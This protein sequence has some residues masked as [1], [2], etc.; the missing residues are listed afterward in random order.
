VAAFEQH[1]ADSKKWLGEGHEQVHL[2]LDEYFK[3]LGPLHRKVRHHHEG[4][5]QIR[6][7]YGDLAAT[8]ATIHILRDCRH[9]PKASHYSI[10]FVDSLGLR[11][12]WPTSAYVK[13]SEEDFTA[14][15]QMNLKG[16]TGL[17]LWSFIN[18]ENINGFLAG[19]TTLSPEETARHVKRWSEA[20]ASRL[21]LAPFEAQKTELTPLPEPSMSYIRQ[22]FEKQIFQEI[23]GQLSGFQIGTVPVNQ[24]I[25]PLVYVD[26]EYL[27]ELRAELP[28][29]DPPDLVRFAFPEIVSSTIKIVS[30][31]P[32]LRS[33]TIVSPQKTLTIGPLQL[34]TGPAGVEAKFL[35]SNTLSM[36]MVTRVGDRLYLKNG[37]H[38]AFL[39]AQ[40]GI[41]EIPCIFTQESQL[42]LTLSVAYPAFHPIVL[43]QPRPPLLVDLLDS[44]LSVE[45]PI[46]RTRKFIKIS[47]EESII[48]V[49]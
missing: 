2:L 37:I 7:L 3:T 28:G 46:H 6:F 27:E 48:P 41:T 13:F 42:S 36:I 40:L 34:Q 11:K 5:E 12:S 8:A 49:D 30:Q 35:I 43:T 19:I 9:V 17:A 14:L 4:V 33:A 45:L 25:C 39:L 22:L 20:F 15:V 44:S 26:V 31:D 1:V 21:S 23:K 32:T 38:R 18:Q 10:G 29:T 47:A 24:L 16:P